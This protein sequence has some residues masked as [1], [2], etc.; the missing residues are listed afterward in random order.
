MRVLVVSGGRADAAAAH[1][2]SG[3][4][5]SL[6]ERGESAKFV[7]ADSHVRGMAKDSEGKVRQLLRAFNPDVVL[8]DS[9][10]LTYLAAVNR[11]SKSGIV[12]RLRL[13]E[14]AGY[15]WRSKAAGALSRVVTL[16]PP[17]WE[18][19]ALPRLSRSIRAPFAVPPTLLEPQDVSIA[20]DGQSF[21]G[22]HSVELQNMEP[23]SESHHSILC[24]PDESGKLTA[25]CLRTFAQL[26]AR[27]SELL[28]YV[29]GEQTRIQNVL[30]HAAALKLTPYVRLLPAG[31]LF[32]D[33]RIAAS[34]AWVAATG[35]EGALNAVAA[36][37]RG[38]PVIADRGS[39][40]A[41]LIA[42]RISG[43]HSDESDLHTVAAAIAQLLGDRDV[44]RSMSD[45]ALSRA[46]RL[47]SW[48]T[49][50][51]NVC[52]ALSLSRMRK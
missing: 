16:A 51:D 23:H 9:E 52:E 48:T 43:V 32:S 25:H 4:A 47:H 21:V 7:S 12:R 36:M 34:A 1:V 15:G 19:L 18:S 31:V 22:L 38:I 49:F 46:H 42:N 50:M 37:A 41:S 14:D 5:A 27:R 13:E 10:K 44:F 40:V 26:S 11:R 45:G 30:V 3:I 39:N 35:D 6:S 24:V 29:A 20:R 28:L 8:T 17:G 33:R 2:M